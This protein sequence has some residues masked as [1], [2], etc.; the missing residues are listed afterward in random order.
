MK[1]FLLALA[2]AIA[3]MGGFAAGQETKPFSDNLESASLY[4]IFQKFWASQNAMGQGGGLP[5]QLSFLTSAKINI[6]AGEETV[7]IV[8]EGG[9]ISAVIEGGLDGPSM[10][11]K[12]SRRYFNTVI[13]SNRPIKRIIFGLKKGFIVKRTHGV[14]GK[15]KGKLM[16]RA[17]IKLDT[18]EP[19]VRKRILKKLDEISE[20]QGDRFVIRGQRAGL[21]RTTIELESDDDLSGQ[22]VEIEEFTGYTDEAPAGIKGMDLDRGEKNLGVY[23]KIEVDAE[24]I[25]NVL[26]KIDYSDEELEYGLLDEDSLTIKWLDEES[27][28]W[29]RLSAGKPSWVKKVG[30]NKEENYVFAEL[31]HASVYGVSGR[32]I[33]VKKL[34]EQRGYDPA[35]FESPEEIE[36]IRENEGKRGIIDQ[37]IDFLLGLFL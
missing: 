37:I 23:V 20:K 25:K 19:K 4:E 32:I 12:T 28:T 31:E 18:P 30:I 34:E 16:E 17:I 1:K 2:V 24:K 14:M 27:G 26:L 35:Y 13:T 8:L 9:K 21:K 5:A 36:D 6:H 3:F 15:A 11:F 10:E 33:S 29:H 7:G 22:T